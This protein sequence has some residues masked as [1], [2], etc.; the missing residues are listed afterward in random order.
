M[1]TVLSIT[2]MKREAETEGDERRA[3]NFSFLFDVA[4]LVVRPRSRTLSLPL[5]P[6]PSLTVSH[7]FPSK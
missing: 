1:S 6:P 7:Q 2:G 4:A 5:L 3:S